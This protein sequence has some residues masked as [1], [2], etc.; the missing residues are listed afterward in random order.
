MMYPRSVSSLRGGF[1]ADP[2]TISAQQIASENEAAIVRLQALLQSTADRQLQTEIG[3][4][5]TMATGVKA[6]LAAMAAGT[7]D[8]A[9]FDNLVVA[10]QE[11]MT[12]LARLDAAGGGGQTVTP[13]AEDE[14]EGA[15]LDI[16]R[17]SQTASSIFTPMNIGIGVAVL[18]GLYFVMR[19]RSGPTQI[20]EAEMDALLASGE[21]E[22]NE[23]CGCGG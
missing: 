22:L 23:D 13:E 15:M 17:R 1:H 19:R 8:A 9:K 14:A 16:E 3:Q 11:V 4:L 12:R 7:K 18:A 20:S 5:F 21:Y 6:S 2:A 10:H